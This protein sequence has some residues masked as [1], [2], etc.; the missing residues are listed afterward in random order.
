MARPKNHRTAILTVPATAAEPA[1]GSQKVS[2]R[3]PL[4]LS[5]ST[6]F[7][8][9]VQFEWSATKTGDKW[10]SL[11]D[12]LTGPGRRTLPAGKAAR[13]RANTTVDISAGAP[14]A[15]VLHDLS[16]APADYEEDFED[17]SLDVEL[18]VAAG[19]F[20]NLDGKQGTV[21]FTGTF[22]ATLQVQINLSE[23][24]ESTW[25]DLG[26]PVS[27][28]GMITIPRG[29]AG[30]I[31]I[32]TT[33]FTSGAPVADLSAGFSDEAVEGD[34]S[35]SDA[36]ASE[37]G[38]QETYTFS[39]FKDA[40]GNRIINDFD[41]LAAAVDGKTAIVILDDLDD[42]GGYGGSMT[43]PV[44]DH[45]E[46][47]GVEWRGT[48]VAH[49][50]R[51]SQRV[52]FII[53]EGCTFSKGFARLGRLTVLRNQ[54]TATVPYP[55]SASNPGMPWFLGGC[56]SQEGTVPFANTA[57]MAPG[58]T[59]N[60]FLRDRFS[61]VGVPI[62]STQIHGGLQTPDV[63][64]ND[65]FFVTMV[66]LV[67]DGA[68]VQENMF[69][70]DSGT[71]V[72]LFIQQDD[73]SRIG[74]QSGLDFAGSPLHFIFYDV[75]GGRWPMTPDAFTAAATAR[76]TPFTGALHRSDTTGGPI[77]QDLPAV[78]GHPQPFAFTQDL[79]TEAHRCAFS[80][81]GDG[82]A[83]SLVAALGEKLNGVL[84]VGATETLTGTV[85][86]TDAETIE[87]GGKTYTFQ[88]VLTDVDG[89]V[90]IGGDLATSMANLRAAI[91]L[92][93]GAGTTYATSMTT[94]GSATA[95]DTAT[96]VVATAIIGGTGGNLITSTEAAANASWGAGTL[97]GGLG[98]ILFPKGAHVEFWSSGIDEWTQLKPFAPSAAYTP[99]NV[100]E[101]R[102][103]DADAVTALTNNVTSGGSADTID[104]WSDLSTYATDAAAIRNA[105]FRL[106]EKTQ[107]LDAQQ[108]ILAD[109]LGTSIDDEQLQGIKA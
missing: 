26:N 18:Q 24:D 40:D 15:L 54:A 1:G 73:G 29:L 89:N 99:T 41:V 44:G 101:V 59:V 97:S 83:L 100:S 74:R 75:E 55:L 32:D 8:G 35:A 66:C 6:A 95:T 38:A 52:R 19:D 22:D 16:L 80:D 10:F 12:A 94:N 71:S 96:T 2:P 78:V 7:T 93:A 13:V 91:N 92:D 49:P 28:R 53:P 68:N 17:T 48:E 31:R 85:N 90:L 9:T 69:A 4:S 50:S 98:E 57:G 14:I 70:G 102:A 11:G 60:W 42:A 64:V 84:S 103:F 39:E 43:F 61:L 62:T 33:A 58:S 76:Q 51:P 56:I 77:I 27:A 81:E 86:F 79:Q 88:T 87:L 23:T 25:H 34:L 36:L 104:D 5:L 47:A 65:G 67:Q 106:A 20:A 108:K 45:P 21:T 109:A 46:F 82:G 72:N 37:L 3:S 30:R 105:M 107:Q 63:F